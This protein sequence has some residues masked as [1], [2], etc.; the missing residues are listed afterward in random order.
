MSRLNRFAPHAGHEYRTKRNFDFGP[1]REIHVS[2]LSPYL[3]NGTLSE[4]EVVS[5]VLAAHRFNEAEK[6]LQEVFW[7]VYWKGYLENRPSL[8]SDYR[9]DL[10]SLR[11]DAESL[12]NFQA[13]IEA[14]TGIECFDTWSK[15]LQET[16]YLH[17]HARMWFASIWIFTLK[18]PWQLGADFFLRH[19]LDGDPASNTLSWRWVAGLHTKGKTYLAWP[20]N[21]AQYTSGRFEDISGLATTAEPISESH[22][23][24]RE[25][26]EKLPNPSKALAEG[27]GLIVLDED[28]RQHIDEIQPDSAILG[29]YP[30][31]CYDQSKTSSTVADFRLQCLTDA[32]SRLESD[33][34]CRTEMATN[35]TA[36]SIIA[37][38]QKN[39]VNTL[40]LANPQIGPW[41]D[42]W[43]SVAR[44]L[45]ANGLK[46]NYFR[47]WWENE[48]YPQATHGFFKFNKDIRAVAERMAS[49]STPAVD[50]S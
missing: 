17:N 23:H 3:R 46:I 10:F 29:L 8:W 45:K 16:G 18:L 50:G 15:E 28:L 32:L 38:A 4:A 39:E 35:P 31:S 33:H 43:T 48:L 40:L 47:T 25:A 14:N 9:Q 26:F 12:R 27:H 37:W 44:Q 11:N 6:F 20:G 36:E 41:N 2:L 1:E 13:A 22:T 21:I 49:P 24:N 5:T 34:N 42:I 19:L 7:R 30:K